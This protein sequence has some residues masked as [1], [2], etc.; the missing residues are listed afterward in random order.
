MSVR[1]FATRRYRRFINQHNG[2]TLV[3]LY[4]R[5][6]DDDQPDPER[7]GVTSAL[8][9]SHLA[10]IAEA[11]ATPT[12]P[13]V[14]DAL[15]AG[16]RLTPS[17]VCITFDDGYRDNFEKALPLLR[18]YNVPATFF[19]AT[20]PFEGRFFAWDEKVYPGLSPSTLYADTALL[21]QAAHD[22]LVTI[23]AHTHA[24]QRLSAL[25]PE[26]ARADIAHNIDLL[27]PVCGYRPQLFS[28]PFG[29]P[30]SYTPEI[31]DVVRSFGFTGAFTTTFGTVHA[32]RDPALLMR[33]YPAAQSAED[34][35]A[36]LRAYF[37]DAS[38]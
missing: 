24:H 33:Y 5:L 31:V 30:A 9:E 3:L 8:F 36:V 14:C 23:G 22:P 26:D 6:I 12:L 38:C 4:H 35:A 10:M 15:Q 16:K 19:V 21:H 27:T 2:S 11:F 34:L 17:S 13:E 25:S 37:G 32:R 20:L 29:D 1:G 28:Y 7:L 18:R